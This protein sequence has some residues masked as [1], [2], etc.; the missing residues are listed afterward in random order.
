LEFFSSHNSQIGIN[1]IVEVNWSERWQVYQRLNEL[2]I[3]CC[4]KAN[5]PLQVKISN[6]HTAIQVWSVVRQLNASRQDLV[7]CLEN[8]WRIKYQAY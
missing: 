1:Q 3:P 7:N 6:T 5:Q 2:D 4:C 8:C